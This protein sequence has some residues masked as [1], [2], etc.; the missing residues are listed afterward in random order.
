M[1]DRILNVTQVNRYIKNIIEEDFLLANITVKGEITNYRPS[2]A[3]HL[4]FSVKDENAA[5][6]CVMFR[7]KASTLNIKIKDGIKVVIKG[8]ISLYEKGGTYQLIADSIEEEGQGDLYKKFLM[9][10]E[11]LE[12]EGLFDTKYK[13]KIPYLPERV[14]VITSKTGSVIRDIINVS[15]RRFENINLLIYPSAVQGDEV[16]NTV[17]SGIKYFN[18]NK[19][20]DVIIIA[21]GGGSFEDLF[22]F[23]DEQIA[24][25]IFKSEI[26]IVSAVGHETD[27]TICDLVADLRAPT[28]S[29]AAEIVYKE[30]EKMLLDIKKVEN[31][32]E[33]RILEYIE[34]KKLQIENIKARRIYAIPQQIID[35]NLQ[36]ID[37]LNEKA[38][39]IL[40]NKI[41]DKKNALNSLTVKLDAISPLKTL[42]RGYSIVLDSNGKNITKKEM[43]KA[44]EKIN[45]IVENG[46]FN[47]V[48]VED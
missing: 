30:K 26:P 43:A 32:L 18:E 33:T 14:G 7:F 21:R 4:Y 48:V 29:A 22:G 38:E 3:G 6:S 44:G 9:L 20:V 28:P 36:Y 46:N 17:I 19:N 15:K 16:R 40:K 41:I 31:R 24:R 23:N 11:S 8:K 35:T 1:E 13:K 25:E 27:T 5:L 34:R 37:R 45:V 2:S 47:A 42:S 12:K 39:N 10:K